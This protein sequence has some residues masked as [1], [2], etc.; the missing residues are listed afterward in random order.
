MDLFAS[1]T[2][3]QLASAVVLV[4][5]FAGI[6]TEEFH[7]FHRAKFALLGAM[8][9]VIVGQLFGFYSPQL[10]VEAIDWN[11]VFLLLFMMTI[12]AI[13]APTGGFQR[14]AHSIATFAGPRKFLLLTMLGLTVA[15]ISMLL[16]NV[17]TVIIFG[18]LIVIICQ[19]LKLSPI[20]YLMSMAM[21]SN[22]GGIATLV[23]DPPNILIGSA[24]GFSF[25][26]FL[27]TMLLPTLAVAAVTVLATR[28]IFK[29]D[30]E[31]GGS[32]EHVD[33][34]PPALK[35]PRT[36]WAGVGVMLGMVVLFLLHAT[37]HWDAWFVAAIG[38]AA[39]LFLG[40]RIDMDQ[41]FEDVEITLLIFFIS[42]FIIVGGV[43]ESGFLEWIG[44][45]LVPLIESDLFMATIVLLWVSAILSA[46]IDNIPFAA[47]MIPILMSLE[48]RG[49]SIEPLWWALA[50]GV[51]L[52]GNGS[53]LG[54]TANVF[55]V[56]LTE[57]LA[58]QT[59][60]HSMVITPARWIR[61]GTPMML[62][63]LVA[64][65]VIFA[66]WFDFFNREVPRIA[67]AEV[68]E[69]AHH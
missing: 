50:M 31:K 13:L 45:F 46:L 40:G 11:V 41:T 51:G 5:A 34:T 49:L 65:S 10:A 33:A 23:G 37:L 27:S 39:L 18:P 1:L 9:M 64:A 26:T 19:Q 52:G 16:D 36:W 17:T 54:S 44:S 12:V 35:R 56:G 6:F 25:F 38:L 55:V 68:H 8:G 67:T 61:Q 53:H 24:A 60:D 59:K 66:V 15:G 62:A 58:K 2:T 47:A 14:L 63:T 48:A 43:E 22:I 3:S 7:G 29:K 4:L 21:L 30:L 20:P 57:R 28:F 32:H 69:S 42:L